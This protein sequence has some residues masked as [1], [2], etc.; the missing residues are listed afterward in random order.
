MSR[1][2]LDLD[3]IRTLPPVVDVPTAA[4]VL[5]IG[6]TAAYE[7]IRTDSWPTPVVRL[8]KLIRVPTAPLL[9]LVG[10]QR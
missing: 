2:Q 6:R 4:A 5:G 3:Q 8:G 10:V 7:L 9:A 1:L